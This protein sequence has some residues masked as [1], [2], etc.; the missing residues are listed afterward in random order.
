MREAG[1]SAFRCPTTRSP[2]L[3]WAL[4]AWIY[5]HV[6][7]C[8]HMQRLVGNMAGHVFMV[9]LLIDLSV[10]QKQSV[11]NP[12]GHQSS[13]RVHCCIGIFASTF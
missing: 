5:V 13:P 6:C 2:G 11:P 1:E 12:C 8:V 10:I 9:C 7:V 4:N 3:L